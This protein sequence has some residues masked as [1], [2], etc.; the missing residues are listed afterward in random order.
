[1]QPYQP[2]LIDRFQSGWITDE[3]PWNLPPDAFSEIEN[4]HTHHGYVEKRSG[5]SLFGRIVHG[6]SVAANWDVSSITQAD[7]GVVTVGSTAGLTN[8]DT[9]VFYDVTG[10]TEVNGVEFTISNVLATTF[11][12]SDTS[13]FTAYA[14]LGFIYL[15]PGERV[16]GLHR[17][18]NSDNAKILVGFDTKRASVYDGPNERFQPLDSADIFD[19]GTTDYVTSINWANAASSTVAPLFRLYFTNGKTF[20][21]TLNGIRYYDGGTST[22]LFRPDI[23]SSVPINGCRFLFALRERL[24]LLYTF[25]GPNTFPQRARWCQAQNPDAPGAWDDNTPGKGGF[26]DAPTGDQIISAIQLQDIVMVLMT[27]SVWYISPTSDPALPFIWTK[28]N[29][30][31]SIGARFGAAGFDK[32]V[33]SLGARGIVSSNTTESTLIDDKIH[34]FVFDEMNTDHINKVY[35]LRSF[36]ER[37]TWILYPSDTSEECNAALILDEETGAF[38]KYNIDMNV[39][40]YGNLTNDYTF[41]DM[42]EARF[43]DS[44]ADPTFDFFGPETFYSFSFE[45]QDDQFLGGDISGFVYLLEDTTSDFGE[46]ISMTLTTSSLNAGKEQGYASKV[47]Y[48][49]FFVNADMNTLFTVEF[50]KDTAAAPYVTQNLDCLPNLGYI[51][52]IIDC[53]VKTP[54]TDGVTVNAPNHGLATGDIVYLYGVQGMTEIN[55]LELT[56]TVVDENY[57][58]VDVDASSYSAYSNAGSVFERRFFKTNVWK[59]AYAG[60]TGYQH[61]MTITSSGSSSPFEIHK[62]K[63]YTKTDSSRTIG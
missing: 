41:D 31:R 19:S 29:D 8:G 63:V 47:G 36:A 53:T 49:D 28:V 34:D 58:D 3:K 60:G 9:I 10:M 32:W 56:V 57:F 54:A 59:R 15:I 45:G 62:I 55:D 18:I 1:M 12:I 51:A 21:I 38:S 6:E 35:M 2:L 25:E 30:Y 43:P 20:N 39:L 7:P 24:I 61:Q 16:M 33:T 4:A 40:G 11:E 52:S 5:Y 42:T 27:N 26:V 22:T 14:G 23:N 44:S 17:Y 50:N 13:G 46:E 48:V 37:R